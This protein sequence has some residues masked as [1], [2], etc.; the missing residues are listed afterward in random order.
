MVKSSKEG[1][2]NEHDNILEARA[3]QDGLYVN[4]NGVNVDEMPTEIM[5][6][7]LW[8]MFKQLVTLMAMV[9]TEL[10]QIRK[11]QTTI[12][13]LATKQKTHGQ[14][15][16]TLEKTVSYTAMKVCNMEDKMAG[17]QTTVSEAKAKYDA[18]KI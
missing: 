14:R 18:M 6:Q 8:T 3:K 2:P 5:L 15:I 17:Y 1:E 7:M 10:A 11:T 9:K 4:G 16:T 12:N 13:Q